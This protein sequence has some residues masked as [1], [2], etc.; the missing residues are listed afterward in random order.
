MKN[1]IGDLTEYPVLKTET[2]NN[3]G[4]PEAKAIK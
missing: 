1:K 3:E 4:I 2:Q